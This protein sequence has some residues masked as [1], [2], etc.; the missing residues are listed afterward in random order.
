MTAQQPDAPLEGPAFYAD[1]YPAYRRL[2]ERSPIHWHAP[3]NTWLVARHSDAQTVLRSPDRFSSVG[4]QS[5]LIDILRPELVDE[6]PTFERRS[7]VAMLITSDPPSHTRLRRFLQVMFTPRAIEGLRRSI[8]EL[9]EELLD[10]VHARKSVDAVDAIAFPL[11]ALV[12]AEVFGIPRADRDLLKEASQSLVGFINRSNPNAEITVQH[13]RAAEASLAAFFTY[14][15]EHVADRAR[16]PRADLISSLVHAEFD[17]VRLDPEEIIWNLVLFLSA[18]HE[19]TTSLISSGLFLLGRHEDQRGLVRTRPELISAAIE[20]TLRF[21]SP[22]Q[23]IKRVVAHDTKLGRVHLRA[24]DSL[25]VLVGSANRDPAVFPDPDRFDLQRAPT[26]SIAFG[27]GLHF[28][29]GST[30]ARVEGEIMVRRI[31]AR[32]P[33]YQLAIDWQPEWSTTTNPRQ[34]VSLPIVF[35]G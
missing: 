31:L 4:T 33:S 34:L 16:N 18:G 3:T 26:L 5:K 24:G 8:E 7:K 9:A 10:D 28:C 21:E 22:I 14:L 23:R 25:H 30:L 1:P 17:G 11:P 15:R 12:I 6:V 35:A 19:T 29:I 13:A 2:R 32:W 27:K 20:E